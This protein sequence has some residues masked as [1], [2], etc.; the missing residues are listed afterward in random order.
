MKDQRVRLLL[1]T[2]HVCGY[3][4]DR[5]ARS[6]FI[7]PG[8]TLDSTRYG[9]LLDQGFRRSG[10]YVYRPMCVQCAACR[11]ARVVVSEFNTRRNHRRCMAQNQAIELSVAPRLTD[12]H[13]TL[14]RRYLGTRHRDGGMDPNDA[15]AFHEFLNCPWGRTE[16]WEFREHGRLMIVAV[17]DRVPQGMS[18]VYTFFE[19]DLPARGLGTFAILE[20]IRVAREI[21]MP[22]VYLGYWV[23]GSPTMNYKRNFRPLE[24]L[25]PQGWRRCPDDF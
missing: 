1:G 14:Y 17:V 22:Y 11:P 5:R 18:A 24:L 7:D 25:T 4:P 19:P 10:G 20:Q 13:F 8:Y 9:V 3:L 16:F 2:E 6:A 15:E 21:R 12:E 23:P